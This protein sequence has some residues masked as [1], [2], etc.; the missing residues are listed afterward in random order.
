MHNSENLE[1]KIKRSLG[2]FHYLGVHCTH[3]LQ[4]MYTELIHTFFG[5]YCDV[6]LQIESVTSDCILLVLIKNLKA[7]RYC[8]S[9][10]NAPASRNICGGI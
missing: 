9:L 3:F 4:L 1:I 10:Q 2:T 5:L 7:K 6:L 8:I